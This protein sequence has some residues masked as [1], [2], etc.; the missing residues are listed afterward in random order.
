[1]NYHISVHINVIQYTAQSCFNFPLALWPSMSRCCPMESRELTGHSAALAYYYWNPSQLT[2]LCRQ[3]H[4]MMTVHVLQLREAF[5]SLK[6][7]SRLQH[8]HKNQHDRTAPTLHQSITVADCIIGWLV[9]LQQHL[10]TKSKLG[11]INWQVA[12]NVRHA[13]YLLA[14]TQHK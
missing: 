5:C 7:Q 8:W 4:R 6:L 14:Y 13:T 11:V 2:W 9:G 10:N 1:M 12:K 3:V